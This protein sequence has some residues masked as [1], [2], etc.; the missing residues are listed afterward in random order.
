[1]S[2][3]ADRLKERQKGY[4]K[5]VDEDDARR[6]RED[7]ALQLRK[8]TREEALLKKRMCNEVPP[9]VLPDGTAQFPQPPQ[10]GAEVF[11]ASKSMGSQPNLAMEQI[12]GL[13]QALASGD[14]Q[15]EFNA[16]QS[17]RKLLSVEQNPPINE[18]IGVGV[19]PKFVQFLKEINRP[20][21]QFEAAW[22]LTNIASGT[23]EQTRVV[24]EHGALPIFVELLQSPN[25]DVREQAVWALGNI[26]GDSPNFRDLVLQSGGLNPIMQVLSESTKTSIMR[27][28]T[29][30]LSN[31][32]RGKPP[33]PLEWVSPATATL[34]NLI[35]STDVEV[36]T[37]AC[38]ALSYLSDGPNERIT[39]VI[40]ANVCQR[41][42]DLL[43]HS[44]P[45]VQTP[46]LRAVGNIV[47]GDDQQTQVILM[48]GVLP[49][50][51]QLLEHQ[52]KTIRKESC[53]TISNIT[54]GSREQIQ[55]VINNGLIPP[56]IGLLQ[57]A[58]FDIKKEA[59]WVISNTTAGGLPQHIGYIIECGCIKP[60]VDLLTVSD[61]RVVGVAL[62]AI[63]NILKMGKSQQAEQGLP[64]NPVVALVEQADGL[65]KIEGLQ[66]DPNEDV[67]QKAMSI[68]ENYFPLEDD[69]AE[70]TANTGNNQFQFGA[71]MPQGG[72]NFGN[73][74]G[75]A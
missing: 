10:A 13:M 42:V 41:L 27:N 72:F 49:K 71:Q 17:F 36:L 1:M 22:V 12:P 48:C 53:W 31:L 61:V 47:T 14:P 25:E 15:A 64:E 51:L 11:D 54:A 7:A 40:N 33:P 26:A 28:A 19:V 46:A 5:G 32:C 8:Q 9:G 21:L 74:G 44:S 73:M 29:W 3:I 75:A 66:E 52:K 57:N 67:Y 59:A 35:H 23:A 69:D 63:E 16:T 18:V 34:A 37:D 38:W 45:L 50:L 24:V 2:G 39:A 58:D 65:M 4:K 68:L 56:I 20:D 70:V 43:L 30:T 6:K 62:E 60:M 55:E